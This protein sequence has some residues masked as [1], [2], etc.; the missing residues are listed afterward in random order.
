MSSIADGAPALTSKAVIVPNPL[1]AQITAISAELMDKATALC[2]LADTCT[3]TDTASLSRAEELF[4]SI[5][6]FTKQVHDDRMALTRQIDALK[7]SI[8]DAEDKATGPLAARKQAVAKQV[9]AFRAKLEAERREK[10]RL[11]REEAERKAAVIRQQQEAERKAALAKWEADQA[12]A[13]AEAEEEAAMF[14]HSVQ[15]PAPVAPP[16]LAAPPVIPVLDPPSLAPSLPKSPVRTTTRKRTVIK[17]REALLAAA[18]KEGGNLHGKRV[19][20]INDRAVDEL[21]RA[22]V[23]VPGAVSESYEVIGSAGVR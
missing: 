20:D 15:A 3:V 2:A 13:K 16:P 12:K 23:P 17:D 8:M 1:G 7:R 5:D 6:G 9:S 22:G 14:G 4:V 19:L 11:A 10:E 18:C 21:V